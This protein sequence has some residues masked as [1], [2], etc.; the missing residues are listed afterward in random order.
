L[1]VLLINVPLTEFSECNEDLA[2][3]DLKIPPFKLPTPFSRAQDH[4]SSVVIKPTR[5]DFLV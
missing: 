1:T 5:G 4:P 2:D 3:C